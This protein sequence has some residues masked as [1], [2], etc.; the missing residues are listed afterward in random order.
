MTGNAPTREQRVL[1][2]G[3]IGLAV[4]GVLGVIMLF[5]SFDPPPP[6]AAPPPTPTIDERAEKR[7]RLQQEELDRAMRGWTGAV[8][9]ACVQGKVAFPSLRYGWDT[10]IPDMAAGVNQLVVSVGEVQAPANPA[11]VARIDPILKQGQ[12]LNQLW[13]ALA[14]RK[15]ADIPEVEHFAAVDRVRDYIDTLVQ[16]G[17]RECAFLRPQPNRPFTSPQPGAPPAP[18]AEQPP[19]GQPGVQPPAPGPIPPPP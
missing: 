11:A 18:P 7:A 3:I 6:R 19:V 5:L 15:K 10:N 13:S 14:P 2:Y 12:E 8:N 16:V 17:A 4:L 9:G 1:K